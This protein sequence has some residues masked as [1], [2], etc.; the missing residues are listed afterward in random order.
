MP[1]L[2]FCTVILISFMFAACFSVSSADRQPDAPQAKS[3][4][5]VSNKKIVLIF[6]DSLTAGFGLDDPETQAY[7]AII[8]QKIDSLKLPYKVVNGGLSGETSAGG[9]ARIDWL[10]RQ[11]IEVFVLELGANDGLR[12]LPVTET[13]KNL[14]S[15]IN[16]VKAKYP[17]V[18]ILLTGMMVPPNMGEAY[19]AQFKSVYP[20]LAE[21]NHVAFLPFLLQHVA[22]NPDLNQADGIHPTPKGAQIVAQNVWAVLHGLL[23][24]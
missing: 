22:G 1:K 10:L 21:K 24:P 11:K 7:P 5:A 17:N 20:A 6:G 2:H 8:Q 16:K 15:I 18:K 14:Q 12:G 9:S 19:S 4:V 23:T 13:R 3:P